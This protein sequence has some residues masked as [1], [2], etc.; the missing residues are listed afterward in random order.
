[1]LKKLSF[2]FYVFYCF[3]VGL[4]LAVAPWWLP[5]WEQNYFFV[6]LPQLKAIFLNGFFRGAVS[7]I[8]VLNV[9][10]AVIEVIQNEKARQIAARSNGLS[11][12]GQRKSRI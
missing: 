7:G 3:E 4:F 9:S 11:E 10:L 2:Y 1:M 12:V 5:V 8:G 6:V